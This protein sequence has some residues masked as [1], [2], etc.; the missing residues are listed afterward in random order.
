MINSRLPRPIAPPQSSV[1]P[2]AS[3]SKQSRPVASTSTSKKSATAD[4]KNAFE[5]L[6]KKP[7]QAKVKLGGKANLPK[8]AKAQKSDK[9]STARIPQ[10]SIFAVSEGGEKPAAPLS[11][12]GMKMREKMRPKPKPKIDKR[13]LLI[14]T[15]DEE[16]NMADPGIDGECEATDL[17]SARQSP[18][19]GPSTLADS[20]MQAEEIKENGHPMMLGDAEKSVDH[21]SPEAVSVETTPVTTGMD[22]TVSLPTGRSVS[23][24]NHMEEPAQPEQ[25]PSVKARPSKLPLGKK[26]QPASIAP[27]G[28]VTRS[29]S[30]QTGQESP[31]PGIHFYSL[32]LEV[33]D[34]FFP[35][36]PRKRAAPV[37]SA[38]KR[39][40]SGRVK[41]T[42]PPAEETSAMDADP[43][44]EDFPPGSPMK[45]SSPTKTPSRNHS[46]TTDDESEII[47]FGAGKLSLAKSPARSKSY[48]K[49]ASTPS[50][51]K[52]ARATSMFI[53]PTSKKFIIGIEKHN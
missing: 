33:S 46:G 34:E 23:E 7:F 28:R 20:F 19:L 3:T 37:P 6:M 45:T 10:P 18:D 51:T 22:E 47:D 39:T 40:A 49:P 35:V 26:R 25:P 48:I 2:S 53:K 5:V 52:I 43:I 8:G 50:P 24:A 38:L 42:A 21:H 27:V 14:P 36:K 13:P 12:L 1:L 15:E 29:S 11:R 16:E 31:E 9:V 41:K 44:D 30:K 32:I 4:K 17:G